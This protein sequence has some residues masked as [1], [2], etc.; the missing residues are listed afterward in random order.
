METKK[1]NDRF[2]IF[3]RPVEETKISASR[4]KYKK[5]PSKTSYGIIC[6]KKTDAGNQILLIKKTNTYAF[7]D[8]II[9]RY[10]NNDD[11]ID[12]FNK[13]TY[14]EKR[15]ILYL[16][17]NMLWYKIFN[18]NPE[19][20]YQ[21]EDSNLSE[22]YFR[23]K[24]EF[25]RAFLRDGGARLRRFAENSK[26]VE[27]IWEIPKGRAVRGETSI[28]AAIREFGEESG[29]ADYKLDLHMKPFIECYIDNRTIYKNVYYYAEVTEQTKR[30][31]FRAANHEVIYVDWFDMNRIKYNMLPRDIEKF[32]RIF[33]NIKKRANYNT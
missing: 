19:Q 20:A 2:A 30:D 22:F 18:I 15:D 8:F 26:N 7:V 13:M 29:V 25:E 9:G 11:I 10:R 21:K 5:L 24:S 33:T 14:C 6:F 23:R 1:I 32:R 3:S 12:L 31:I 28:D 27:T 17:F 4:N 16:K